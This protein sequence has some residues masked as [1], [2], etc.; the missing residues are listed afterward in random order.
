MTGMRSGRVAVIIPAFNEEGTV[1]DVVRVARTLTRDVV[2]VSDGS[3]DATAARAREA[4]ARV[5]DLPENAGKG[6]ALYAGLSHTD[7]EFVLLLDA[8]LV[9]LQLGHLQTLLA[10]V[11]NGELDM[12]IGVFSDGGFMT[13]FGN[14]MTPHLSGQRAARREWLLA[15]PRLAQERW[16]EPAITYALKNDRARWGYVELPKLSQVMKE[17]KRGLWQG[18]KHR[19][20]MYRDLLTYRR[21][22]KREAEG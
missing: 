7:A 16:P 5:I 4:G 9:N 15:V 19:T 6:P 22:R 3:R 13:D 17:E 12:A 2:V 14:R 10:P 18:L 20:R 21:R 8:D 1:G 11:A